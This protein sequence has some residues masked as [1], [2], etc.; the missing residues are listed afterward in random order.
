MWP[1]LSI[2]KPEP[3]ACCR[4]FWGTGKP[5]KGSRDC[6]ITTWGGVAPVD[7]VHRER[8]SGAEVRRSGVLGGPGRLDLADRRR[9]GCRER[10]KGRGARQ[11][12]PSAGSGCRENAQAEKDSRSS[13]H[14]PY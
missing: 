2:T 14:G 7:L 10:A 4:C 11:R 3:R 1:A 9:R 6:V 8:F 13:R 12:E 5:K